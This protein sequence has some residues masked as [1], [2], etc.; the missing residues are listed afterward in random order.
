MVK[1]A[2]GTTPAIMGTKIT[3]TYHQLENA[4]EIE[5]DIS[6]SV[7][8]QYIL[9]VCVCVCVCVCMCITKD[10]HSFIPFLTPPPLPPS[11]THQ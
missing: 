7:P 3:H 4:F 10:I 9:G 8:A 5:V 6:S 2:V 11:R 1:A